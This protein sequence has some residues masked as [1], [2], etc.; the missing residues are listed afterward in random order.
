[1][2]PQE[3]EPAEP[4]LRAR[5]GGEITLAVAALIGLVGMVGAALA[6]RVQR[7]VRRAL[8]KRPRI[9]WGPIPLLSIQYWSEGVKR[10]GLES[11]TCV[12]GVSVLHGRSDFDICW[13]SLRGSETLTYLFHYYAVTAW[14]LLRADILCCFY[15]GSFLYGSRLKRLEGPLLKLAGVKLVVSPYGSDVAVPGYLGVYEERMLQDYPVFLEIGDEV[16]ER[17]DRVSRWADL[18]IGN[19]H[20]LGYRP[21]SDVLWYTQLA[22]DTDAWPESPPGGG[23]GGDA[24]KVTV[25]HAPNHRRIKGTDALEAAIAVLK[26]E[27]L[28]VELDMLEGRPNSEVRQALLDA[29]IVVDQLVAGYAMFAIEGMSAGKPVMTSLSWLP[30]EILATEALREC[31]LV[32]AN[33][34]T[35][36]DELRRLVVDPALRR[37]LGARSRRFAERYHSLDAAGRTWEVVF[38]SLWRGD[39]VPAIL[40]A[41]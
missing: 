15:E 34:E 23:D 39:P 35:I 7:A 10:R 25:L 36:T 29:D 3:A 27:G 30:D 5:I 18:A 40:P 14:A 4:T 37:D 17:V 26:E 6:S 16:K 32:D 12:Y 38:E 9:V 41:A 33:L 22:I 24:G 11:T 2:T 31:P 28:D 20:Q 1:M 21:R 19:Y 13:D 8:G